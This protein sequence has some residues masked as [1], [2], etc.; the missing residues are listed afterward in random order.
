[1]LMDFAA[2][3]GVDYDARDLA[4]LLLYSVAYLRIAATREVLCC[5]FL[6]LTTL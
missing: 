5:K 4:L 1:M 6:T 2:N 3:E